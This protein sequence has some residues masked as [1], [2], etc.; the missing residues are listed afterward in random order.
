MKLLN[1]LAKL[2]IEY[3]IVIFLFLVILW[4]SITQN[5]S[6]SVFE[7]NPK[8]LQMHAYENFESGF[9]ET[10]HSAANSDGLELPAEESS[11]GV[12]AIFQEEGLTGSP[13]QEK[14]LFDPVSKLSSNPE[15]VG[16]SY[17]YSNS[18]GGLC[19]DEETRNYF[20][21]RGQV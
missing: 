2:P 5:K 9:Q 3:Y 8:T 14:E 10:T 15:C 21:K 18:K 16:N 11:E 6:F 17:G 7:S 19:F 13:L 20:K 4:M 12:L 1:R